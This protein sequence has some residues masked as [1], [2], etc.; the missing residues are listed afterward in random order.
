MNR[1]RSHYRRHCRLEQSNQC[2]SLSAVWSSHETLIQYP[3]PRATELRGLAAHGASLV[4]PSWLLAAI[5]RE[6]HRHPDRDAQFRYLN[7]PT[8]SFIRDRQPVIS[9][10]TKKKELLGNCDNVDAEW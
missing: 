2:E 8:A 1:L 10:D 3:P 7:D 4:A 6:G 5:E 9:V